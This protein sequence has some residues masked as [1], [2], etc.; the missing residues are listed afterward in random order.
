MEIE[1]ISIKEAE[2]INTVTVVLDESNLNDG[3]TKSIK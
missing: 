1:D 2:F 3:N